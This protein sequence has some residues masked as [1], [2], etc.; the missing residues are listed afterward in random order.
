MA[1]DHK[2]TGL[3]NGTE[4]PRTAAPTAATAAAA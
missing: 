4:L 3:K 1:T 2:H